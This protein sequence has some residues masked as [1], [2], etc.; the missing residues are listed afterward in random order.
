MSKSNFD[1]SIAS[2]PENKALLKALNSKSRQEFEAAYD[3]V[4]VLA[5]EVAKEVLAQAPTVANFFRTINFDKGTVPTVPL[6]IF[7]DITDRNLLQIWTQSV[8]GGLPTNYFHGVES[9]VAQVQSLTSAISVKKDTIAGSVDVLAAVLERLA[10]EFLIT[11][12][13]TSAGVIS[14]VI[15][16]AR[17][18]DGTPQGI[19]T[20][21][22]NVF[23]M[24]DFNRV[25]TLLQRIRPSFVG[26][27]PV[28]GQTI[29]H[30]VG[31]PEFHEQLRS[32][33][34]Q[35]QNTRAGS[36]TTSGATSLAAPDAVRN[37]IFNAAGNAEFFGVNLVNLYEMGVGKSYNQLF[38]DYIGST[39]VDGAGA[40]DPATEEVIWALSLNT[41]KNSL[42]RLVENDNGSTLN[43]SPDDQFTVRSKKIGFTAEQSEG[44][45]CTDARNLGFV[46]L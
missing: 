9:M 45:L 21:T 37:S 4:A 39:A 18:A 10:Q 29:S 12:E 44:R 1:V 30:L 24:N 20:G 38:A 36:L 41:N 35:P 43:V 8:S 26:G 14:A 27:T 28:S 23:A 15:G 22:A 6:D 25:I 2:T 40:F 11:Q 16:Q 42:I 46:V 7:Y 31:S 33:A 19:R 13:T 32:M 3:A 5:G 17:K 34:Y